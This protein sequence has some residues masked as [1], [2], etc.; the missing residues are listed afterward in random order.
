MLSR[1][2]IG[3][4]KYVWIFDTSCI[5]QHTTACPLPQS[6]SLTS[7]LARICHREFDKAQRAGERDIGFETI[8]TKMVAIARHQGQLRSCVLNQNS[9][10][11]PQR[12]PIIVAGEDICHLLVLFAINSGSH[13]SAAI[14]R[15][16][17]SS[18]LRCSASC[19]LCGST[20]CGD[21]TASIVG[22]C[23]SL[24]SPAP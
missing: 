10:S 21:W 15:S 23:A 17:S 11:V 22:L 16:P 1:V 3:K 18:L 13:F 9:Y 12:V 5:I 20:L 19:N 7:I 24:C 14:V 2:I 6:M 4:H 8:L